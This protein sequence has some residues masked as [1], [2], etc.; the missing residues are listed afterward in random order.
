VRLDLAR[1]NHV[2]IPA[3]KEGRDRW[4]KSR[5]GRLLRP[6]ASVFESVSEE[7]AA[8]VLVAILAGFFGVD[9]VNT[10]IYVLWAALSALLLVS[11][12]FGRLYRMPGVRVEVRAPKRVGVGEALTFLVNVRND[13][14]AAVHAVRVLGPFLPW[15]GRWLARRPYARVIAPGATARLTAKARF[16]ARGEHHLDPFRA[17]QTVPLGL[18]AGPGVRSLGSRFLVVPKMAAIARLSVPIGRR[19]QPG[20]V[21]LASKTGDSMDLLGVRPYRPGD[22]VRDLH[23]KTWARVGY[24]VVREYQQEFFT[25]VGIALDCDPDVR[26]SSELFESAV[27]LVAGIVGKLTRSEALVD[28]MV[29]GDRVHALTLGRSLG[30]L[31][32]ALD[33]LACVAP[34]RPFS[35]D[36]LLTVLEPHLPRLSCVIFV[37]VRW[38]EERGQVEGRVRALGT[39]CSTFLVSE[40]APPG[41]RGVSPGAIARGEPVVL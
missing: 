29:M 11:L 2:L 33:L 37:A 5:A 28:V 18:A 8:M 21:A 15:D 20:G 30:S 16:H 39:A 31:E 34:G 41:V 36:A 14:P 9:V 3:S 17:A 32:Q 10:R 4:R 35:A 40:A 19:H 7:G 38:D 27:S 12:L 6:F 26:A 24:P 22:P 1:W 13:G 23:S 25:R